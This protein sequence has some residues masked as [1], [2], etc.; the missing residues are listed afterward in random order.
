MPSSYLN[1][2]HMLCRVRDFGRLT[3]PPAN[4]PQDM[5]TIRQQKHLIP[6]VPGDF[7]ID[8]VVLQLPGTALG[9]YDQIISG[10]SRP[11]QQTIC[12]CIIGK[13]FRILFFF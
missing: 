5:R 9:V 6:L 3:D 2:H 13:P 11:Q 7:L 10:F 12:Y 8:K 1:F 4:H